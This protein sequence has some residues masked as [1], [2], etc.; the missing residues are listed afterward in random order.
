MKR[1]TKCNIEKPTSEFSKDKQK[2][3]GLRSSC[4]AC[5]KAYDKAYVE[6]NKEKKYASNKAWNETN[7][8]YKA[9]YD[10]KRRK[11]LRDE[12]NRKKRE[13]YHNGGKE[14]EKAWRK[15]NNEKVNE[16]ARNAKSKRRELEKSST[17]TYS[18]FSKWTKTQPKVCKYCGEDC[19]SNYH[20]DH[21]IPLSKGGKHDLS[22]LTI[23]CQT[24]NISKG[25]KS[26]EEW[27]PRR[28]EL[29]EAKNKKS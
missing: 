11:K 17:I 25:N 4:K 12:I 8:N 24:C 3:D 2:K 14:V 28:K 6:N 27:E 1:C 5:K 29:V 18:K 16:Y 7:P 23:A 15:L 13:Y 20:V 9:A 21:V 22:N 19:S 26:L 10:K